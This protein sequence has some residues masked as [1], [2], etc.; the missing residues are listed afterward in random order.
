M[1]FGGDQESEPQERKKVPVRGG[2]KQSQQNSKVKSLFKGQPSDG[3]GVESILQD[4]GIQHEK[5]VELKKL[6]WA[7]STYYYIICQI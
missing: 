4:K 6:R 3:E 2:D 5:L 1:G 7:F